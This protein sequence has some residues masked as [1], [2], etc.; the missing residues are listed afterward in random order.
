MDILV[1]ELTEFDKIRQQFNYGPYPRIPLERSPKENYET[2]FYHNLVTPYY[3]R[4]HR[5]I[6]TRD[7]LI[8]DAGCGSGYK[9]LMLAEANPGA[10]I[11]GVDI[12]EESVKRAQQRLKHHG[13]DNVQ[14]HVL[15]IEN[16]PELGLEFDYINCDEVLYLLPDPVAGL[17]AMKSVLKPD[18]LMRSNLH[19]SYQRANF[20]RAQKL[21]RFMGL[22]DNSPQEFEEEAV[23]ATMEAL[24]DDVKLKMQTWQVQNTDNKDPEKMKEFLGANLLLVGDTGYTIP[25]MFTI[26]EE[27][28]LEFVTMVN[29]RHWDVADLFKDA[30]NLPAI[31]EMGLE[32]A[33][34]QDRLHLYELL[35]PVHRL[36][37]FWCTHS[38]ESGTLPEDWK[39]T[40][41]QD[42]TVHLHPQLRNE[43][44]KQELISAIRHR[45]MFEISNTVPIT[46]TGK[47]FVEPTLAACLLPLWDAP[48]PIQTL[49]TRYR[50]IRPVDAATLEPTTE[51]AAHQIV[52]EFLKTLN[53]FMYILLERAM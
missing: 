8:L 20:Y 28:D 13:F 16:L 15:N 24:K 29:W 44:T 1:S 41:W 38:G 32:A 6:D 5:V 46:V 17:Q 12:S 42:V 36:L 2:L 35:N 9:A 34:I 18:G 37:D 50:Q 53:L 22:F 45:D 19:S 27:S 23:I 31:W 47:V 25:E 11:V 52:K 30:G 3:L 4:H 7:K 39:E 10:R 49:V 51:A 21:F 26:L 33:S 48:Q 14:F 40:D 43:N